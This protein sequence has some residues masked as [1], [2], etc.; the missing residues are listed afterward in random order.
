MLLTGTCEDVGLVNYYLMSCVRSHICILTFLFYD[1]LFNF[2]NCHENSYLKWCLVIYN[3]VYWII[4]LK[5]PSCKYLSH[6]VD[7]FILI[8]RLKF[9]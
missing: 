6:F 8:R 1:F 9:V 5:S 7:L 4:I 3:I 2:V